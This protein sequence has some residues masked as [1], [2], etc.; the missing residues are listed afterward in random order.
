MTYTEKRLALLEHITDQHNATDITRIPNNYY[1]QIKTLLEDS[2]AQA[3]AEAAV[4][5]D[6]EA[7]F[8][9]LYEDLDYPVCCS[10]RDCACNKQSVLENIRIYITNLLAAKDRETGEIVLRLIQLL[11]K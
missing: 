2:I 7:E 6:W 1:E 8:R 10:E 5:W 4:V 3:K 11:K 9:S